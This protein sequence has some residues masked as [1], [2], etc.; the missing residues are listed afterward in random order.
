M[1]SQMRH[2][3]PLREPF[4]TALRSGFSWSSFWA[5]RFDFFYI[6]GLSGDNLEDITSNGYDIAITGKDFSGDYIPYTSEAT[7]QIPDNETLKADDT[8]YLWF[9]R[10]GIV[11]DVEVSELVGY[12]FSRTIVKYDNSTPYHI[13]FIGILK[14]GVTLSE[15]ELTNLYSYFELSQFWSGL[16]DERGVIKGNR[17]GAQSEWPEISTAAL[18]YADTYQTAVLA[19][20]GVIVKRLSLEIEYQRL[21]DTGNIASLWDAYHWKCGIKINVVDYGLGDKNVVAKW[22]NLAPGRIAN[23]VNAYIT[24]V[25]SRPE[26]TVNGIRW[27][28]VNLDGGDYCGLISDNSSLPNNNNIVKVECVG[29]ID[30]QIPYTNSSLIEKGTLQENGFFR[31]REGDAGNLKHLYFTHTFGVSSIQSALSTPEF[32]VYGEEFNMEVTANYTT[33][34]ITA[35]KDGVDIPMIYFNAAATYPDD[36]YALMLG[37]STNTGKYPMD[38]YIKRIAL[39]AL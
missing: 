16:L 9:N 5:A 27:R 10:N 6:G 22:Y 38:G 17:A 39:Y 15:A 14:S 18:D 4:R 7:F 34:V 23:S 28:T 19:D 29:R 21:I 11:R 1:R 13:R 37:C 25:D 31:I 36:N 20:G 33:I 32:Y 35:T 24:G 8:D 3:I 30:S 12:D 2:S 26:Y